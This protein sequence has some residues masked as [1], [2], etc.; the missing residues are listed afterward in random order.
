ME[1]EYS[2]KNWGD[3]P[4][5]SQFLNENQLIFNLEFTRLF[6]ISSIGN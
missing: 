2:G 4:F 1:F 3:L 6:A 5:D